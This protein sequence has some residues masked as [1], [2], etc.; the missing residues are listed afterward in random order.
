MAS[1]RGIHDQVA[2]L[3]VSRS[4][5]TEKH[6]K[7]CWDEDTKHAFHLPG[8][9]KD[10]RDTAADRQWRKIGQADKQT[11]SQPQQEGQQEGQQEDSQLL[12]EN[13]QAKPLNQ[14]GWNSETWMKDKRG[15]KAQVEH[16]GGLQ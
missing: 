16:Q 9:A 14:G 1:P 2:Q 4:Y 13:V 5:L 11:Q 3:S 8:D 12:R 10:T 7:S 6:P 15:R